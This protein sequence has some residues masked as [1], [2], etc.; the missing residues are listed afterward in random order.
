MH[1]IANE[2]TLHSPHLV[3]ERFQGSVRLCCSVWVSS[4]ITARREFPQQQNSIFFPG[5]LDSIDLVRKKGF[6]LASKMSF[7]PAPG[8]CL[9]VLFLFWC[10]LCLVRGIQNWV[11]LKTCARLSALIRTQ[12]SFVW[13]AQFCPRQ[14][15]KERSLLVDQASFHPGTKWQKTWCINRTFNWMT[16]PQWTR[17][18]EATE[19]DTALIQVW[20]RNIKWE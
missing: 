14:E 2:G 16:V 15:R 20:N 8:I 18:R 4:V 1:L 11:L 9:F 17:M 6:S 13:I 3:T 19:P 12:N 7:K 10:K 5:I